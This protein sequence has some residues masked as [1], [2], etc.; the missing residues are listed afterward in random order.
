[1]THSFLLAS[2]I[3]LPSL[4][5]GTD[6]TVAQS[7]HY[8]AFSAKPAPVQRV[9]A[10]DII[11]TTTLDAAGGDEKGVIADPKGI[12]NPLSGPFYLEGAEPGDALVLHITKLRM[13]RNWGWTGFRLGPWALPPGQ[14]ANMPAVHYKA[15]LVH[16]GDDR[17]VPWDLDLK[18]N[19]VR[20]REPVSPRI[21]LEFPAR[22]ML[23]CIGVAAPGTA[24]PDS[25]QSG[26]YGGNMD[27]N[28][29][30][31]GATVILPVYHPGALLYLGDGHA[32][33]ADGEPTGQ[34]IET[35]FDVEFTLDL[36]KHA[37]LTG[38][39]V[40]TADEIISVG[41]QQEFASPLNHALELATADMLQWL[42]AGYG[43]EPWAA[44]VLVTTQAR[45]QVVTVA[46][47][48]ALRIS[49][50]YLPAKR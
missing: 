39:R 10:G 13:N 24:S 18:N 42:V 47:S 11:R 49:K 25:S 45:Y 26:S 36:V 38:P 14:T 37:G 6:V 21:K 4:L 50:R 8:Y 29:A 22:P 35:S 17:Q 9:H 3:L 2:G 7:T 40:E 20:L 1:M 44:H 33:Q 27:Y 46:G 15:D 32:L 16:K 19:V 28:E 43:L 5:M 31:E 23:G 12:G 41:S 48:M 34:G 30:G